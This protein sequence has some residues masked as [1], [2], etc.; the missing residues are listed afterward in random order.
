MLTARGDTKLSLSGLDLERVHRDRE[1]N[2]R[3]GRDCTSNRYEHPIVSSSDTRRCRRQ[4]S[5]GSSRTLQR[6]EGPSQSGP[7]DRRPRSRNCGISDITQSGRSPLNQRSSSLLIVVGSS[8]RVHPIQ[9][10]P[11]RMEQGGHIESVIG[12]SI[13]AEWNGC[14][15]GVQNR[16][17]SC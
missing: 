9:L 16:A 15:R 7:Q 2:L 11:P 14:L 8:G 4:R 10:R 3:F 17:D 12:E 1:A 6:R 5:A 13:V